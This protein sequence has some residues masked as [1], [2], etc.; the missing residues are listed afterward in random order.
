MRRLTLIL[1][2][3]SALARPAWTLTSDDLKRVTFD[4]HVGR[5]VSPD[6]VFRDETNR[7]FRLGDHFGKQPTI[8]V[9]GYYHCPMLCTLINDGLIKA[10]QD[11]P[12]NIGSAFQVIDV[13]ID[14]TEKPSAAAARKAEYV[15]A[16]GRPGAVG[17]WHCLV[18]DQAS[19]TQLADEVGYR[20]VYDPEIQQYAHPSG[21]VLLTPEGKISHYLFG[22][23]F[24]PKELRSSLAAAELGHTSSAVSQFLLLCYCFNPIT[25][26]Y[27]ALTLNGL[28][29]LS[30]IFLLALGYWIFSMTR[31]STSARA[32]P[33]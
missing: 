17:G 1:F 22:V 9:L 30:L 13:S 33:P 32:E 29:I 5:Q 21:L 20:Y 12:L 31:Q 26:K 7:P 24:N 8:L 23:T 18:A 16:Y 25:G 27:G 6:L 11:V 15:R 14:P 10:L 28:R 2:L 19:I 4:Q 3:V